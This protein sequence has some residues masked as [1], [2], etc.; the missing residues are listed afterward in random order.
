[1]TREHAKEEIR[2]SW[3]QLFPADRKR[4][5]IICPLCG[6]G[7][8]EHGSGITENPNK[9]GQLKCWA[10]GF[11][12]DAIDLIKERDSLS[13]GEAL[14]Q[15]AAFLGI[16][17]DPFT[18]G[19]QARPAVDPA[20]AAQIRNG[21]RQQKAQEPAPE[22]PQEEPEEEP[23]EDYLEYF[24]AC[25]TR[26]SDPAFKEYISRRGISAETAE[27]FAL[28]FD[29]AFRNPKVPK[30]V[31]TT[32]RLI[33][34]TSRHSFLARDTRA[35][36]D[37]KQAQ[38]NKSKVGKV[39]LY[40]T[41]A[42]KVGSPIF[43]T[44]GEIDAISIIEAGGA[45]AVALGSASNV[46]KLIDL[47]TVQPP[48]QPLIFALDNDDTGRKAAAKIKAGLL[49]LE[50]IR[51]IEADLFGSA[52]DA[53]EALTSDREAFAAAVAA[54]ARRAPAEAKSAAEWIRE[55][56]L[57]AEKE[58]YLVASA[59]GYIDT[60]RR[61]IRDS[62]SAPCFPTGFYSLDKILDG[63]LYAGLYVLGAISS[64][65]KTTLALQIC[66]QIAAA[67]HDVLIFSL[68]MAR[69]ELMAK[70]I[71]RITYTE[72]IDD[73]GVPEIAKTTRDILS[74][75]RWQQFTRD[76]KENAE[77]AFSLY[78]AFA[79]RIFIFEGVGNIGVKEIREAVERHIVITGNKPVVLVDYLQILAP[80]DTRASDKQ[81]TDKAV[82]ELKRISRDYKIPLLAVSSFN[83]DNYTA[84][85][86]MASFKESGAVEYS[87]D[88][89]IG[90]QYDGMEWQT[91][92]SEK[93]RNK[94]VRQL[95]LDNNRDAAAGRPL[96]V[97]AEILK[98]R[99]GR[100]SAALLDFVAK[101]NCFTDPNAPKDPG[102]D[103]QL[104]WQDGADDPENPFNN[105]LYL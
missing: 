61:E 66:D 11:Q 78:G 16:P 17:L 54:A 28:G 9:P 15:A 63:G 105:A 69:S 90:L 97:Q 88:V 87:S 30:S 41:D 10:C 80:F 95:F 73:F 59:A 32:P 89:L 85:V 58:D 82:L 62:T 19:E 84:P 92:E 27:R 35:N 38:Y 103:D 22:P 48:A 74:G 34:P 104:S 76:E 36:L 24:R 81:N 70:S 72:A 47:L 42:L 68:E 71:S 43:L 86:N 100:R 6:S 57:E 91:G 64:L 40:N 31:P 101:Y 50:G 99:N 60:L 4:K 23:E 5:G 29:P 79:R 98:N 37:K 96:K 65:G 51:F 49:P 14:E 33:I 67:G 7:S 56:E 44:E 46:Q 12:G 83:R 13:Y 3:K 8:K 77:K 20:R 55:A 94:R 93:E 102:G 75:A 52:K 26:R 2:R 25:A 53:N 1:M 21:Q 18:P 39:R 45:A